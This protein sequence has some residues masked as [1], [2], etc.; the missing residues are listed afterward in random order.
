LTIHL[1]HDPKEVLGLYP[2]SDFDVVRG[3]DAGAVAGR[4][5]AWYFADETVGI[6]RA[7]VAVAGCDRA[8]RPLDDVRRWGEASRAAERAQRPPLVWL[9]APDRW[10]HCHLSADARR[11]DGP[12]GPRRLHLVP[13]F[14]LNRSYFDASSA[15]YFAGRDVSVR[16]TAS[17]D[18]FE[19]RAVWP[20]AARLGQAPPP[21][22]AASTSTKPDALLRTLI[23]SGTSN[24]AFSTE[25]LWQREGDTDWQGRCV[26]AFILNGAQG[27]DDEA[28][29]GHFAIATGRVAADGAIGDWMVNSFY[30]LDSVSEKNIVA[31]PVPLHIYQGDLNA[32]QSWYRPS[33]ALVVVLDGE[34]AALR[35]QAALSR[36][37]R[38]FW[39]HQLAYYHPTDNCTSMSI[40]TLRMLGLDVP[41]A[42]ATS[43]IGAWLAFPWLLARERSLAKA[44]VSFDYLVAER[45]RLLPRVALEALFESLWAIARRTAA[46][47]SGPLEREIAQ[48]MCAL[49]WLRLPQFPSSRAQGSASVASI[50][51]Y[52]ARV[53]KDPA[54]RQ[55]VPVPARP[56]PEEL[57]DDDLLPPRPHLSELAVRLW[58]A[59]PLASLAL[60]L[61]LVGGYR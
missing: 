1:P 41:R 58:V 55:V 5:A 57:R 21:P 27:D 47:A 19:L 11:L 16:G 54:L 45:T 14:E 33:W 13:K 25:T 3:H 34:R 24:A 51:E 50:A 38:H 22:L 8:T 31:A 59:I 2:A 17:A 39:R 56:F 6:P 46:A 52:R 44:K 26:L 40:D 29:A 48:E 10:R 15:A 36:V 12:L 28:H 60:F 61:V 20:E 4:A 37:Y 30:P 18:T 9:A 35:V 42:G 23:E 53:P 43:R 49:A 32:G 7:G